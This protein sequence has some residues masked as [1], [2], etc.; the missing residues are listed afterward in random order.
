MA[1]TTISRSPGRWTIRSGRRR[2]V[3][4]VDRDLLREIAVV[5]HPRQLDDPFQ[6]QFTPTAAHLRGPQGGDQVGCL[7]LELLL[8]G[9][10]RLDVPLHARVGLLTALLQPTDMLVELL[11]G[12]GQGLDQ[13][14]YGFLAHAEVALGF[15]EYLVEG[16][17]G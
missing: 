7:L 5:G 17:L 14:V 12:L 16:F 13:S 8:G 15:G 1:S 2:P 3:S 6:R 10:Q 9:R 11:E 4:E